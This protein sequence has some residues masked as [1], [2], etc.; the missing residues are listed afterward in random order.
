MKQLL[1]Q[2]GNISLVVVTTW[3]VVLTYFILQGQEEARKR[4]SEPLLLI[5]WTL[6]TAP[7]STILPDSNNI[8]SLIVSKISKTMGT[9]APPPSEN[10]YIT[11]E[12]VNVRPVLVRD[13]EI[14]FKINIETTPGIDL[15][16]NPADTHWKDDNLGL[17]LSQRK[18]IAI[19]EISTIPSFVCVSVSITKI[20]YSAADSLDIIEKYVGD[21]AFSYKGNIETGVTP[22]RRV[23][24]GGN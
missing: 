18:Y 9:Y 15:G 5:N 1:S 12:I 16:I 8:S 7:G 10:N 4:A 20:S 17:E 22:L 24:G 6:R 3:Y 21:A 11:I 13:I 2:L 14:L 23:E 19:T